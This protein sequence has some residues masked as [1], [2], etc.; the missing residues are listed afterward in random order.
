MPSIHPQH[1][2]TSS[3]CAAVTVGNPDPFLW[4]F[5]H[6][7]VSR[8]WF[9]AIHFASAASVRKLLI[10][11]RSGITDAMGGMVTEGAFRSR[12]ELQLPE[13]RLSRS[14][15]VEAEAG[16]ADHDCQ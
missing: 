12:L 2:A 1:K 11:V 13:N 5:N 8:T 15:R 16:Q 4:I 10:F 14:G 6:S 3:A 7:S 9:E